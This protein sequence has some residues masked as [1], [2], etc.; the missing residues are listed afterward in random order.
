MKIFNKEKILVAS[1]FGLC[2]LSAAENDTNLINDLP[3]EVIQDGIL[4]HMDA[5]SHQD[6]SQTNSSNAAQVRE[7]KNQTKAKSSTES[8]KNKIRPARLICPSATDL[9]VAL[10]TQ[11]HNNGLVIKD[12]NWTVQFLGQNRTGENLIFNKM[13][14]MVIDNAGD[15]YESQE[16][17]YKH[18]ESGS[19]ELL[20]RRDIPQNFNMVDPTKCRVTHM[21]ELFEVVEDGS[22]NVEVRAHENVS[23]LPKQ[24][25]DVICDQMQSNYD[26]K[27]GQN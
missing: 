7:Y 3:P 23:I 22:Y 24:E 8:E 1:L 27:I 15:F 6:F 4:G 12:K 18:R 21:P 26:L 14:I 13:K 9:G 5:Q 11:D 2:Q 19:Q 16:C 20:I 17:H 10:A 25:I